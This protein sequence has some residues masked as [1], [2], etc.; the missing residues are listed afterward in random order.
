[1]LSRAYLRYFPIR[2]GKRALWN[3]AIR[4]YIA[5]RDM[6]F[7]CETSFGARLD[8]HTADTVQRYIY[9]FGVWEPALT[10]Y[11]RHS[12][13]AGDV[14][15]DIGAN[16]GYYT[17]LAAQLVGPTGR[18]FA[19]EA[20][21][22]I[23]RVLE[24][25]V[26]ENCASNV[27]TV[28]A[29]VYRERAEMPVFL[30]AADNRGGTTIVKQVALGRHT[31]LEAIV[32]AMPLSDIV[33]PADIVRARMI[34]I[35]VEGAEWPVVQGFIDL[36][37]QL[38]G[39]TEIFVEV[40]AEALRDQGTTAEEFLQLFVAAGFTASAFDYPIETYLGRPSAP[41]PLTRQDF[42]A[43]DVLFRRDSPPTTFETSLP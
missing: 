35:D 4:P 32:P 7:R 6:A 37:P 19:I 12:L 14:F 9:F 10:E 33:P 3:H 27:T 34:K 24:H 21:P 15:I 1:M 42:S 43:A 17:L 11:L 36:I 2:H 41:R 18:V 25:H 16:I 23:F 13:S 29:A 22:S 30:H 5:W 40:N 39:H 28:H 26:T 31:A 8:V 20:S 38:S